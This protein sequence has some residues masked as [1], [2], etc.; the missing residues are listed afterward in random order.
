MFQNIT[1]NL[2]ETLEEKNQGLA[3]RTDMHFFGDRN[4]F[5]HLSLG[6]Y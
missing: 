4:R 1:Y 2:S 6:E 5:F 3:H